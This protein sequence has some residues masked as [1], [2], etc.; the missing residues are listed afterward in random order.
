M[1]RPA[2]PSSALGRLLEAAGYRLEARGEA[3]TA[4]RARDHR[5]IVIVS[6]A[7]SPAEMEGWFPPD[8]IYRTIVYDDDPGGV[9]RMLAADRG[10][11]VLDPSTLGSALGEIL[12]PPP[13][14]PGE[15]SGGPDGVGAL[16]PPFG[17]AIEGRRTVRPRIDRE[18]A[19]ALAG[20]DSP[21]Y[22]LRLV[23][24]YVAAYRVRTASPHGGVGPVMR[25]LVAVNAISRRAE[26]WDE[27]DREL[28]EEVDTPHQRLSPQLTESQAGPL[29]T[30]AIRRHHTT[31]IDHTEQHGGALVIESRR[32]LPSS[33]DVRIGPF[34]LLYVPHW[35]AEGADGRVVLD[36]VTGRRTTDPDAGAG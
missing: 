28:V 35:Y 11:E 7:R 21:W 26:V 9:A 29:A 4:V 12:L 27:G 24:F 33:D 20:V 23:P 1:R 34:V 19:E 18:E 2:P 16:E 32:I 15:S 17:L 30:E 3:T 13:T 36:A 14:D 5:A 8:A 25:Q 6:S 10:I 31:H 22:T